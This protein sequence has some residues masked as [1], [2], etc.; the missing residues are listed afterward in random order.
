MYKVNINADNILISDVCMA[1]HSNLLFA[2][3]IPVNF[4]TDVFL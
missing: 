4:L 1:H 2:K 3:G